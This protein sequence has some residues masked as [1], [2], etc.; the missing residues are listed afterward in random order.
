MNPSA[1]PLTDDLVAIR[2]VLDEYCLRLEVDSFDHWLELFT[3][4][5]IYEV[6]GKKAEG[7]QAMAALLSKAPHGLHI[8]GAARIQIDG[9]EAMTIQ[10]YTFAANNPKYSNNGWYHRKLVKQAGQWKIAHTIVKLQMRE[11]PPSA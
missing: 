6:F 10:N 2:S 9:D 5:T 11:D 4:D 1:A 7:K 3:D 8:G